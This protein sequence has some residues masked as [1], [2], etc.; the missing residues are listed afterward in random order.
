[1]SHLVGAAVGGVCGVI[2]GALLAQLGGVEPVAS[3]IGVGF[4]GFLAG[5][6]FAVEWVEPRVR[7]LDVRLQRYEQFKAA[8]EAFERNLRERQAQ[9][10]RQRAD[11]WRSLPGHAFERELAVLF[12][13]TGYE[14]VTI[15]PGSGD[16]G[17]DIVIRH[18]GRTIIVQCK[19]TRQPVGPAV[20]RELYGAL[21]AF[22][23][24]E[25]I[26]AVTGG[27]TAGVH[28]FFKGKPL[29]VID[30]ENILG[31]Q[32]LLLPAEARPSDEWSEVEWDC[33]VCGGVVVTIHRSGDP[34]NWGVCPKCNQP[35][36]GSIEWPGGIP[37]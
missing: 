29:R 28:D 13:R 27:V 32:E 8:T 15:T 31:L 11:F 7:H 24:D 3:V 33:G 37:N 16:G 23:A 30:L 22:Q 17:I 26:L 14:K 2:L 21:T 12:K 35:V 36:E 18:S 34:I 6:V 5:G 10:L 9:E 1:M 4:L 25:G 20:A 19:Q